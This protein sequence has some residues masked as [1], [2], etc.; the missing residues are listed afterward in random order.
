MNRH[1]KHLRNLATI[2]E[3]VSP[4]NGAKLTAAIVI[5]NKVVAYGNNSYKSHPLQKRFNHATVNMEPTKDSKISRLG[6]TP[7]NEPICGHAEIIAIANA[8]KRVDAREL[9]RATL[10]VARVKY[11]D[12]TKKNF[13]WGNAKPCTVCSGGIDAFKINKVYYTCEGIDNYDGY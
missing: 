13:T 5:N 8:I 10:Y 4:V 12:R 3:D 2:A 6:F 9:S 11:A 1:L 7:P